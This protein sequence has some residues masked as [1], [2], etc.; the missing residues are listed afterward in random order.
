MRF[1]IYNL[2]RYYFEAFLAAFSALARS[3]RLR[4]AKS[5]CLRAFGLA[6]A[7]FLPALRLAFDDHC[8]SPLIVLSFRINT[9]FLKIKRK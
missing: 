5:L 1:T 6:P 7:G 4:A 9:L 3:L 8:T 2:R